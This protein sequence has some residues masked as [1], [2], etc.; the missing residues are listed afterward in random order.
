M[1][2][3]IINWLKTFPFLS[4]KINTTNLEDLFSNG[5]YFGRIFQTHKL[6]SDIKLL[7][8]TNSKDDSLNNYFFLTK[9]FLKLGL[10]LSDL[11]INELISKKPHKA[12]LYLFRIRQSLLLNRIQ[13]NEIVGKME[14]E[15][16]SKLKD[17]IEIKNK[18]KSLF[19]RYQ[20][21]TRRP[22]QINE[23][24]KQSRLQSAQLP[25]INK[26][27]I[28]KI[29][30]M[31][32]NN[33]NIKEK[34]IFTEENEKAHI[35]QMQAVINDI[36]IFENIHMKKDGLKNK[37]RNPWDEINYIYDKD[38]LFNKDKEKEKKY[39]VFDILD[40]ENKKDNIDIKIKQKIDFETKMVKMKSTLNN[41][42]QFN[43]DNK[44]RYLN[45]TH[46]EKGLSFMGLNAANMFPLILKMK[47]N[48]IPSELVMKSIND[49]N[50]GNDIINE[51]HNMTGYL[52]NKKSNYKPPISAKKIHSKL[53]IEKNL[54]NKEFKEQD[55]RAQTAKYPKQNIDKNKLIHKESD[56]TIDTL[57]IKDRSKDTKGKYKDYK[58]GLT[59]IEE[60][61]KG[62]SQNS[63]PSSL[64]SNFRVEEDELN[65]KY[66]KD[67][68]IK[69][70][71][72]IKPLTE[73]E[74]TKRI[75]KKKKD[76]IIDTRYMKEI[77]SSIIDITEIYFDYQINTGSELIDLD[78]WNKISYN[79]I[80][81]KNITKHKK[82]KKVIVEEEKCNLNFNF[83]SPIDEKYSKNF[84]E[85]EKNEMKNYLLN[86]GNK[87]DKNKNCLYVKKL[88][89]KAT[90]LEINDIM[91]NEI[92][93]LFDKAEAEGK[94]AKDEED[95]DEIKKT[96]IVKYRPS[97][98][99]EEIIQPGD[100]I[101]NLLPEYHFTN[102]IS[103]I[104]KFVY[105]KDK[106]KQK[107]IKDNNN[108]E[109]ENKNEI[110]NNNIEENDKD[111][112]F[113]DI[114]N[115]IPIKMS[116]IGLLNT[117]MNLIL[118]TS[119]NKYPKIK[120]Y[121]PIELLNELRLKK[122]KIEEPIDEINLRK[123]QVD[124]LK[125]EKNILSEEIKDYLDILENKDNLTDDEICINI[126]QNKIKKDFEKKNLENIKQEINT[127]RENINAI[128][129]KINAIKEE[130]NQGKKINQRDLDNLQQQIDK[131]IFESIVGFVILNFPNDSKQS[132]LMEKHFMN[133]IQP[134]EQN[135][136]DFDLIND[137]LLLLCDKELKH[138]KS[139]KFEPSIEKIVLF[140][141]N[142][143]KLIK[144]DETNNMNPQIQ[145][146]KNQVQEN[147]II[148]FNKEQIESYKNNFN[149]MEEFYQNFNI[150]ID[151]YDYY[152]GIEEEN[153][154][155]LNNNNI[156]M[157][158]NGFIQR[159]KIIYEKLKSSLILYEEKIVPRVIN[160][161][162]SG[163]ESY[164]EFLDDANQIKEK[165]QSIK[166]SG[167][168]N[169]SKNQIKT[170][171]K[172]DSNNS[173]KNTET[174]KITT[175]KEKSSL[176]NNYKPKQ[177]AI[178]LTQISEE[179]TYNIYNI[180]KNFVEKYNYYIYRIFYRE[181]NIKKKKIEDELLDIQNNFIKFLSNPEEQGILVNQFLE[182]YK[183]L[184]DTF[185]KNKKTNKESN[186]IIIENFQKDL[187]ELKESLW[188]VAKIRKN[189]AFNEIEKLEKE[190]NIKKEIKICYFK[191]ERLILLET[192]KL[193][194][195][196]NIWIRYYTLV[197]NP[198]YI[199]ANNNLV[200]Q[201]RLDSDLTISEELLSD[202]DKEEYAKE[203]NEK[204]ILYP[205][206]NRLYKNTFRLLIKIY[207]FLDDFYNKISV[208]DKKGNIG[209]S[210]YRTNKSKK[211]KRTNT[212]T[213][214]SNSS[215]GQLNY[216]SKI[217][218][219]NQIR[220]LILTYIKKYK[221]KIYDLYMN[222]LEDLSKIFC[223][224]KQIIKLM[225]NWIILS[226]ELQTKN[227]NKTIKELDITNNY[228]INNNIE[229]NEKIERNIVDLII[230]DDCEIYNYKFTGINYQDFTLFDSNKFLGISDL[231]NKNDINTE[232]DYYKVFEYIKEYD[233][234]TKLKMNEIQ[235]GIITQ[236]KFDEIFFKLG[237]FE[238][239]DKF[240]TVFNSI[241]YHHISKFLSH[242]TFLSTD[243]N[244]DKN[245]SNAQK[246]LYTNDIITILIL[247][248][249]VLDKNKIEK[250]YN[251]I[252]NNYINE[253]KF[254]ENNFGFEEEL[255]NTK[256]KDNIVK[257]I[258][259]FLFN[260][261][262]TCSD[263]PEINI[264]RFL[265][266][267][268]LKPLKGLND[269]MPINKYFDLFYN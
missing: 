259:G 231:E 29:K 199:S 159:D 101:F 190:N 93:L 37:K 236:E 252:E 266:L 202:L 149:E 48:K 238:N 110:N 131:I 132:L 20:S 4:D 77:L 226:M 22:E 54:K 121:N 250:I 166:E 227:I 63:V 243:F 229:E 84:G 242:F 182:K 31:N 218:M 97:K 59:K 126:L 66:I 168:L 258:K 244:N 23:E 257:E 87:Y 33:N 208:R 150:K 78:K 146:N 50:K 156:N 18:T 253:E 151:K 94:D 25:K 14:A 225:D 124:Q 95:E 141:C 81:N 96:G 103:E 171:Q 26:L 147:E 138:Q 45:R 142:N 51:K 130:Q 88:G 174:Q 262:K 200:P 233:I 58:R 165:E 15:S 204:T 169:N 269:E 185:C 170:I 53:K 21:A 176:Q 222:S 74:N 62:V 216:N 69:K 167:D 201:F 104:I 61:E 43:V 143:D 102:F 136:S 42:N 239:I 135:I 90:N 129:E 24:K 203:I 152:E 7:K 210:A 116:I 64:L 111:V 178:S 162:V 28:K 119:L 172:K 180:W 187:D 177:K 157:N 137:K 255:N 122:K 32:I 139:V 114:L 86:I 191:L 209:S 196:I 72:I 73:E 49:K 212:N 56:K 6:F 140:Y 44:K 261:N 76:Y 186:K 133:L 70:K 112:L 145:N 256:N 175:E 207:I 118:K 197:F 35:K 265:N 232:E 16:K 240:P 251:S 241:D 179:E 52:N 260:I 198:K 99:E 154:L 148:G 194:V 189:Q 183:C 107:E 264:K 65:N 8:N 123:N 127:K 120:V 11:D 91:G 234:V 223:P 158:S 248:C 235:K 82:I 173:I 215:I 47:G 230:S 38:A 188:N 220:S 163:D 40:S 105:D 89:L 68:I 217:E 268:L 237:L 246:L 184:K 9:I 245:I 79:F 134:C 19:S 10:D 85:N 17:E 115:S 211:L 205:R 106:E 228:N 192:Q 117:E 27:N 92:Q 98:T 214:N 113:K 5:F 71:K 2:E 181:K 254:M 144:E 100:K 12:E 247:S 80:H 75:E 108:N 41:Y 224:F 83:D 60:T 155:I 128:N 221:I 3:I 13:F 125:K 55:K 46:L 206:A 67:K 193:V 1:S 34:D 160:K 213:Q 164:D 267:L 219:Q 249:V 39:S 36:Q 57:H 109:E 30:T 195:I 153:N 161:T 263:V